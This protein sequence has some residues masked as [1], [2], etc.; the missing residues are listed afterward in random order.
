MKQTLHEGKHDTLIHPKE[1][2]DLCL[3]V[4]AYF[5]RGR[6]LYKKLDMVTRKEKSSLQK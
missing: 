3:R 6:M 2:R 5:R 4:V 1:H